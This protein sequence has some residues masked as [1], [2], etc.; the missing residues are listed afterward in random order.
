MLCKVKSGNCYRW[1][2]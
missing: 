1:I 2:N